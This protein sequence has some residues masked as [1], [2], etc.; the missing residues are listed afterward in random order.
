[1]RKD[2]WIFL[3]LF[4]SFSASFGQMPDRVTEAQLSSETIF[5]DALQLKLLEKYDDALK[6]FTEMEKS[7]PSNDVVLFEI[8][9]IHEAVNNSADAIV[10]IEKA[11]I[12]QPDNL[13]YR[14]F[15]MD[16][17]RV[18]ND[19]A[20]YNLALEYQI[21]KGKYNDDH[22][23]QLVKN[24][25]KM[26][27]YKESL[28]VLD[29]LEKM[30]GYTKK[31]GLTRTRIYQRDQDNKKL[32]KELAKLEKTFPSD[33]DVLQQVAT[34]KSSIN[35][36]EGAMVTYKKILQLDPQH[37]GAQ[38][39]IASQNS[40]SKSEV[41]YLRSL[42]IIMEN[43]SLQKDEKIKQLIPFVPK[44][45]ENPEIFSILLKYADIL[46][47]LYPKDPKVNALH[48][49][50]F[51]NARQ[52]GAAVKFYKESLIYVKSVFE[53]WLQLMQALDITGQYGELEKTA[54]EALELYPSQAVCYYYAGKTKLI[55]GK[56]AASLEL[57]E[58]GISIPSKNSPLH[59]DM[60]LLMVD[61]CIQLKKNNQAQKIFGELESNP[62][63][64]KD[65][66]YFLEI[67]GHI[68]NFQGKKSEALDKWNQAIQSG[69]NK[70]R[71][72]K[73]IEGL[74]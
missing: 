31:I 35:D 41:Q 8:A 6:A 61:A 38:I 71:I 34:I 56:T 11:L 1:M 57:L 66:P 63:T 2:F 3:F 17:Y 43:E 64:R 26:G 20:K 30:S 39:Y 33:V 23:Y 16:L 18:T 4:V 49:D 14:Q 51:Y 32:T 53:V 27:D 74:K 67:Q 44:A 48:G 22:F 5:L 68:L 19:M 72:Q 15:A 73:L 7:D 24:Y 13:V 10:Y 69:A 37:A 25:N 28:K 47:K 70:E 62:N 29:R 59:A 42:G 45:A 50:I 60:L 52:P 65:H 40:Q 36:Q 21:A 46:Q 55:T 9:K 54:T 12:L 58:E